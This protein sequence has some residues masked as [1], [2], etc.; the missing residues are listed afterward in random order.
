[1]RAFPSIIAA[2]LAALLLAPAGAIAD[3]GAFEPNNVQSEAYGPVAAGQEYAGAIDIGSDTDWF[4]LRLADAG[5]ATFTF[6][7][8]TDVESRSTLQT[9]CNDAA[10]CTLFVS[11]RTAQDDAFP[12]S[13][14][15]DN[16]A[17]G[18][19]AP[20]Q[21]VTRT[22]QLPAGSYYVRIFGN[23]EGGTYRFSLSG[24][25]SV[26][27]PPPPDCVANPKADGCPQPPDPD[28]VCPV[29]AR[30]LSALDRSEAGALASARALSRAASKA[31]KRSEREALTKSAADKRRD[32][33]QV[34]EQVVAKI[35]ELEK[36]GCDCQLGQRALHAARVALRTGRSATAKRTARTDARSALA[37]LRRAGCVCAVAAD[38]R[39]DAQARLKAA[40]V[41]LRAARRRLSH[42]PSLR[43]RDKV[44][45][46]IGR[47]LEQ[48]DDARADVEAADQA[49]ADAGCS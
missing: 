3:R 10:T 4:T 30:E 13:E 6:T 7:N 44:A 32:A 41:A 47:A 12:G 48:I 46:A 25:L 22:F 37:R 45:I 26:D 1:M 29:L 39:D 31:R 33:A 17:V 18:P 9:G 16:G 19:V 42:Q 38:D 36:V 28:S 49:A 20:G 24:P 27:P 15:S 40:K 14:T 21:T 43:A 2:A 8:T 35:A 5:T 23:D 34:H 11:L